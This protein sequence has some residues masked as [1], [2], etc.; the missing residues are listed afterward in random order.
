MWADPDYRARLV[1]I[2]RSRPEGP[3]LLGWSRRR[4]PEFMEIER[5]LARLTGRSVK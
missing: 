3:E 1:E 2:R 5:R 4:P